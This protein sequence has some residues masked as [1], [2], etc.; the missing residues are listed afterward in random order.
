M[1]TTKMSQ[2]DKQKSSKGSKCRDSDQTRVKEIDGQMAEIV[3]DESSSDSCDDCGDC[4]KPVL[5]THKSLQCDGCGFWH[6]VSSENVRKEVYALLCDLD[7]G[8][9]LL[10]LCRKCMIMHRKIFTKVQQS[11]E[12]VEKLEEVHKRLE[13]KVDNIMATVGKSSMDAAKVQ[14]CVEGALKTQSEEEKAEAVEQKKRIANVIVHGLSEP[15]ASTSKDREAEDKDV[16]EVLLH[17]MSCDTVSVK[18]VTRLGA[19]PGEGEAAKPRP[20]RITFET[21][22]ARNIVLRNAKNLK[23]KDG[24]WD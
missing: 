21:E 2:N 15:K 20:L 16:T 12:A 17:K 1:P 6:H 22:D 5:S 23:G 3:H 13:E 18:Q 4:G 7:S 8:D 9:C 11:Q 10:W 14:E 19:P 24:G